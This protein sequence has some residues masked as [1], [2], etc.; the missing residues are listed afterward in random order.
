MKIGILTFHNIPNF[1]AV[2]QAYS[3]CEALR[4]LGH[5]CEIINYRCDNIVAREL[6]YH[7]N[8]NKIKDI[9]LRHFVWP[10]TEKKIRECQ[11]FMIQNKMYSKDEY[12][13]QTINKAN[14]NYDAFLSGSDMIWDFAVT[15][16]D[17]TFLLDFAN[18]DKI[19][20]SY[21]S[22]C[23]DEIWGENDLDRVR[24]LL[25]RYLGIAVREESMKKK[26]QDIGVNSRV[27]A[28][29]TLLLKPTQ[30]RGVAINPQIDKYVLVYFPSELN[31]EAAS[32]YAKNKGLKVVVLSWGIP[33]RKYTKVSPKS[34]LEWVGFVKHAE[35]IFTDSYHGLL[36]SLYFKKPVWVGKTGNRFA[37]MMDYLDIWG[38]DLK[39]DPGLNY[40]IDYVKVTTLLDKMRE[41]SLEYL[42]TIGR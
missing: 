32:R 28:D 35:A 37:S 5:D 17:T 30:W 1:G 22:S 3:L 9:I 10:S 16:N 20:Y 29:P 13:R 8:P 31:L 12:D 41:E 6:T 18:E 7:P 33:M 38:I 25:G 34:P 23:G 21:G 24:K 4:Q 42:K 27:V 15:N 39:K 40:K 36:Y 26:L 14:N 19:K 2:L 11:E